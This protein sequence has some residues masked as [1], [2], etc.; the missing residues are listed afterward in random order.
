MRESVD[1][2]LSHLVV[3]KGFSRNTLE[4]Y[5]NDLHQ[6]IDYVDG[7][8]LDG[9]AA[10]S[11]SDST[12]SQHRNSAPMSWKQVNLGMLTDYVSNLRIEKSYRD[13][14]TARKVAALKSLF[15]FLVHEEAIDEDPTEFLTAPRVGRSLPKYLSEE[16]VE[17]LLGQA[18]TEVSPDG[19]RD[20]AMLELLYATGLRVTELVSLNVTD[21][22][23]QEG[24]LRCM[25]KGSRER[26]AYMY[27]RAVDVLREYIEEA[28]QQLL[29]PSGGNARAGSP[30]TS[31]PGRALNNKGVQSRST[32]RPE[33]KALFV[34]QRGDRL[35][36]QWVWIVLKSQARKAGL[37]VHITPHVLRHSFATHMLR[38]GASLR[39]VQEL[40]G[41]SSI[42]TT[43]VY[44][45]LT[46]Q[47]V[48]QE[49]DKSHP[50]AS[51]PLEASLLKSS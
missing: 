19:I 37:N 28:R 44:T 31:G 51:S 23:L 3:E 29:I 9:R 26:I 7:Q 33:E 38:G 21:V 45:H 14:T 42:T 2:F 6:F 34:N 39:H 27:P 35:T 17:R 5:R 48:R 11:G 12:M 47:H 15:N 41:H 36:R 1:S 50:R 18:A 8:V 30:A 10:G 24:Y 46:N 32:S 4:A 43:Q 49:Y 13:T 22:S 40:L 16:E 25:G 20:W